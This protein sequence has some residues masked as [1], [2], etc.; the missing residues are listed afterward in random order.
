MLNLQLVSGRTAWTRAAANVEISLLGVRDRER[1]LEDA[2][3][4]GVTPPEDCCSVLE[5]LFIRLTGRDWSLNLYRCCPAPT[6]G[7]RSRLHREHDGLP[8]SHCGGLAKARRLLTRVCKVPV[9]L[10]FFF[11]FLQASHPFPDGTPGILTLGA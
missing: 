11:C 7:M 1:G 10:T 6:H 5:S 8:R 3:G 2:E 9:T 4:S